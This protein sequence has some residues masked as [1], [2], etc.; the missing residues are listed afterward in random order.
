KNFDFQFTPEFAGGDP[1]SSSVTLL[2]VWGAL[3]LNPAF[4]VKVGK[5]TLP[6]VVETGS[7]RHFNESPFTNFLAQNRDL[8]IE[9]YGS[10]SAFIDYRVGV[11][12]G[13][14]NEASGNTNADFDN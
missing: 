4:N 6:V 1:T 2:D 14:R 7:N 12:N 5:Y 9:F 3:K 13:V 10:P 11:F 8:G